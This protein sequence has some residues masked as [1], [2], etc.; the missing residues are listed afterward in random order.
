MPELDV[1]WNEGWLWLGGSLL[2]AFL[3]TNLTWFFRKPRSGTV[4]N[5]VVQ[6]T[7]WPF[8]PWLF[9]F[10]R[11][12]YYLGVP[13]AA[14]WWGHD[15]VVGRRILGLKP[16]SLPISDGSKVDVTIATNWPQDVGWAAVL[17]IGTWAL[18]ALGWWAY[19]RALTA[20]GETS[21]VAQ[22]NSSGWVLLREAAY[23]QVHWAF[24]RNAPILTMSAYGG[25]WIGFLL[26]ALEAAL[27]PAWR[28][29]FADPRRAPSQLLRGTLVIVSVVLFLQTQNLWLALMVDWGVS[30]GLAI[31]VRIFPLL[32]SERLDQSVA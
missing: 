22:V 3:W 15:V 30:W 1:A 2:T 11:L 29:G 19:R 14:L 4:G 32:S 27:N 13:F 17:G 18:L 23:H 21:A 6:L 9:Q 20:V 7:S 8:S 16:F 10:F 12:F 24:Y 31:F 5:F 28:G 26:V 25:A